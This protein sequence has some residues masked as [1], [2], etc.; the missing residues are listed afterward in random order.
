MR[1]IIYLFLLIIIGC[2]PTTT[3]L[4]QKERSLVGNWIELADNGLVQGW[5]M[6]FYEDRTGVFGPITNMQGKVGLEPYMSLLMKDWQIKNDTLSI[7]MEIRPGYSAYDGE[8]KE[9]K[10]SDKP[11][12]LR[13]RVWEASDSVLV[14]E[15]LIEGLP[16]M[17]DTLRKSQKL[18][19]LSK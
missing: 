5:Y 8:G 4:K 9:I 19:L 17:M 2:T 3:Y 7:Q 1:S 6:E 15:N 16:G 14:L 11:S 13:Y 18:E 12:F 10:N